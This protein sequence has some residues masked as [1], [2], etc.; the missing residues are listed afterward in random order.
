MGHYDFDEMLDRRGTNCVKWD[1]ESPAGPIDGDVIPLWVADMDFKAAPPILKVLEERVAHGVF[2]Y[3]H[4]PDSDYESAIN[5]WERRRGWH[6]EKDWYIPVDGI[7][8]AMSIVVTALTRFKVDGN[9]EAVERKDLGRGPHGELPKM[10]IQSPAYNCF[11]SSVRNNECRMLLFP[12][13]WD[14]KSERYTVDFQ[15]LADTISREQPKLFVLCNPH[16]PTG[17]VWTSDELRQMADIC[18]R[19]HVTVLSDEIHCEFVDPQLGRRYQP[20]A[21]IADEVGCQWVVANAPNKAFN[22]AGLMTAY[23]VCPDDTMRRQID[24]AINI[25]EVCDINV[26]APVALEAAYTDEGAEW[27]DQL[28]GY[29]YDGYHRFRTTMKAA[30]NDI[31]I[32]HMEGTYLA[33]M[34]VSHIGDSQEI[35]QRL[36][37]QHNVWLNPGVMYGQPGFLRINL[38]TQHQR[39]E[40]AASRIANLLK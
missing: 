32:A 29:I 36:R 34:D 8:P 9:G 4:I 1:A 18:A 5:W 39:L 26:M 3:T 10:I 40:E 21:P 17:R 38:A 14:L 2:G 22:I 6:T 27:L 7:V 19:N 15:A 37:T 13:T 20:F 23:I 11:F 16:N 25:N 12:L 33:W 28:V 24:R 30:L 35:S 31:P